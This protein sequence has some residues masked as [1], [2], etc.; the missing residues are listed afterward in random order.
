M[1]TPKPSVVLV[2]VHIIITLL[3]KLLTRTC[4][5]GILGSGIGIEIIH[6]ILK[7]ESC[8]FKRN[9]LIQHSVDADV[10]AVARC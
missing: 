3:P 6:R 1:R 4:G 2:F 10:D 5:P 7:M 8:R 9:G